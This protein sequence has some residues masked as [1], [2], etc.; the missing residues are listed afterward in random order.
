MAGMAGPISRVPTRLACAGASRTSQHMRA[1]L[2]GVRLFFVPLRLRLLKKP[3]ENNTEHQVQTGNKHN[4]DTYWY[5]M[6]P[7]EH[8]VG[9]F[10][11]LA[12]V[13]PKKICLIG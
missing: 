5:L 9:S 1:V 8:R 6:K 13:G 12:C 10:A 2:R 11:T 4:T 3:G 7:F